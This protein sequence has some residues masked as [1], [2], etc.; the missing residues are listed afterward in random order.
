M[1][2]LLNKFDCKQYT[3]QQQTDVEEAAFRT[4]KISNYIFFQIFITQL[5]LA[6]M[7]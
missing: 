3:E 2:N 7:I 6:V 4:I 1:L 5:Q